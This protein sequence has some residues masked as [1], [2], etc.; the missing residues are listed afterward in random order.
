MKIHQTYSM[1]YWACMHKISGLAATDLLNILAP[2]HSDLPRSSSTLMKTP[3]MSSFNIIKLQNGD[4]CY[5]GVEKQLLS[6][7][8]RYLIVPNKILYLK[9][10]IDGPPLFKSS[11]NQFWPILLQVN[12][13]IVTDLIVVGMFCGT[14]KPFPNE[15]FLA[16]FVSELVKLLDV[17]LVFNEKRIDVKLLSIICDAPARAY[18]KCI[19][20]HNGYSSCVKCICYGTYDHDGR[21]VVLDDL[22]ARKRCNTSFRNQT[23]ADHHMGTSPF[24][25]LEIDLVEDFPLDYM[26]CVCLGVMRKLLNFWMGGRVP[27]KLDSRTVNEISSRLISFKP[28]FSKEFGRKPRG[29]DCLDRWKATEYRAFLLYAGPVALLNLIPTA[30]Y[31][32][33]VFFC[34]IW[35]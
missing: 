5:F 8:S 35:Q 16:N 11:K 1:R 15:D 24:L 32:H 30:V 3:L 12:N 7:F 28:Y 2:H 19:K 4:F 10:N 17:G 20:G 14:S 22:N 9:F 6:F 31:E 34:Y 29:L 18:L 23:D 26:H 33:F 13:C 21:V 27:V 25:A